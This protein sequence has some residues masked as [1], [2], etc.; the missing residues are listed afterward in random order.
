MSIGFQFTAPVKRQSTALA[1]LQRLSEQLGYQFFSGDS[2]ARV[3]LCRMG[4]LHFTFTQKK[5]GP[6]S[7]AE[8][9]CEACTSTA[10][11]GFHAAAIDF[12]DALAAAEKLDIA[13]EDETDYY[14]HRDFKRMRREHFYSWLEMLVNHCVRSEPQQRNLCLCWS[15]DQYMP[16]DI[17]GT[18]VTPFGR[19]NIHEMAELVAREG[20]EAFAMQFFLWNERE[21]D[22][23]FYRSC[24]LSVLWEDCC[25][26][27]SSRSEADT[28]ANQLALGL[29]EQAFRLDS[30]LPVPKAEY[31]LLCRLQGHTPV[32]I[33]AAP[34]Y[35]SPYPIGY[36]LGM[37]TYRMGNTSLTVHGSFLMDEDE[38]AA[39]WYDGQEDNWHSLR[40]SAFHL[41]EDNA[42][43]S[44]RLFENTA[45]PAEDFDTG[46]GKGRAAFAGEL[47][48]DDGERFYQSI[49][50]INCE[51]QTTLITASYRH[52]EE[53]AWAMA[54][55][56]QIHAHIEKENNP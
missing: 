33:S 12:V 4:D 34:C 19:F 21:R 10:G 13:M 32:D 2:W 30:S 56:R 7:K 8:L 49:A 16:A 44:P 55:F 25:F 26:Q 53:K 45:E 38:N 52:I 31:A 35:Q 9:F 43:F 22:A 50:Q 23:R 17:A 5:Q 1:A 27:P 29:L 54:L 51:R 3:A 20:I 11:A 14:T 18:V 46:D 47:R 48:D 42:A 15:L 36:R 39:L 40:V 37:V 24:A 6:L 28:T 41:G